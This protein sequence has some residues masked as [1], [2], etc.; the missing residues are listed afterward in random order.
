MK[1]NKTMEDLK[2]EFFDKWEALFFYDRDTVKG[3]P[4]LR[5]ENKVWSWIEEAI[6]INKKG[7]KKMKNRKDQHGR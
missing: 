2:K 5:C 6:L 7:V 3:N 4:Y 1:K